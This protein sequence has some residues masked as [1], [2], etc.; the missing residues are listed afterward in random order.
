[1]DFLCNADITDS[2]TQQEIIMSLNGRAVDV[3]MSDMAPNPSGNY[4]GDHLRVVHLCR[5]LLGLL[6][7]GGDA[8]SANCHNSPPIELSPNASF[9]C[10]IWDGEERESFK[11]ELEKR[12]SFVRAFKPDASRKQSSEIYLFAKGPRRSGDVSLGKD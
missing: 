2:G 12:F 6:R 7:A 8:S 3:V 1:V 11:K 5:V 9:V 4:Y 10:K